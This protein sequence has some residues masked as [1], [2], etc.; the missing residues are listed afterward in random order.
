MTA[1]SNDARL[2]P[3]LVRIQSQLSNPLDLTALARQFGTSPFHFHRIFRAATGETPRQ[4]VERLRLERALLRLA[5]TRESIQDIGRAIGFQNHETFSRSFKRRYRFKP[6]E[7]RQFAQWQVARQVSIESPHMRAQCELSEVRFESLRA[8]FLLVKRRVGEYSSFDYAPFARADRLWNPLTRWAEQHGV[9]YEPTAW[10][11]T[12]DIPGLTPPAAQRFDGC[13]RIERAVAGSRNIQ[14][15]RFP[16]G[17]YAVLDHVG[18][19]FTIVAA[20]ARLADAIKLGSDRYGWREGPFL[21]IY[22]T[23]PGNDPRANKT[24]VC[25]P[26]T[27]LALSK[28]RQSFGG[29]PR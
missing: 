10:G 12:Y 29:R 11:L 26:V 6:I 2:A 13:I 28:K 5:L 7:V 4:Y 18:E 17:D 24:T 9:R 23:V 19:S 15:L 22:R 1:K 20:F 16:G 14:C 27:R 25:L 3:F 21:T 8:G